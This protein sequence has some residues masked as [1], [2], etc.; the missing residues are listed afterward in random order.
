M[1]R[2][3]SFRAGGAIKIK[4]GTKLNINDTSS[5]LHVNL[6]TVHM[7]SFSGL[8]GTACVFLRGKIDFRD[9]VLF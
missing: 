8:G 6:I 2:S 1:T 9:G 3:A 5:A 7:L 4:Y